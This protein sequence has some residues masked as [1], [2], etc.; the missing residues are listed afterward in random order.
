MEH[1]HRRLDVLQ[2]EEGGGEEDGEEEGEEERE[3]E[4]EGGG[5]EGKEGE[6]TYE[7]VPKGGKGATTQVLAPTEM[8]QEM[9]EEDEEGG[10][11]G[12]K[13]QGAGAEDEEEG[14]EEE[15]RG[16]NEQGREEEEEV[17]MDVD[18]NE[19]GPARGSAEEER[20]L[21]AT[22]T[23]S[24]SSSSTPKAHKAKGGGGGQTGEND[25][26]ESLPAPL[27][28]PPV[29]E[30]GE[31]EE[32]GA[33]EGKEGD[34]AE[35]GK[36]GEEEDEMGTDAVGA[37]ITTNQAALH[38][39]DALTEEEQQQQQQQ[40]HPSTKINAE[41]EREEEEEEAVLD[42]RQAVQGLWHEHPHPSPD[43]TM[44]LWSRYRSASAPLAL[45]LC[46][47][48]RL[49]LEPL[50]AS[51]LAGD[52]R[53][54]KRINMRRVIPY[55]ASGYR[56]DKIWLRR[57]KPAKRAYQVLLAIDDSGSMKHFEAEDM[58]LT[59]LATLASGMSTLEIGELGVAAFGENLKLVHGFGEPWTEEAGARVLSSF[60]FEQEAT[61]G[62]A[63]L[64]S[65]SAALEAAAG[66]AR[67]R[68]SSGMGVPEK[69]LQLVFVVSDGSFE[70]GDKATLRR[71]VREMA[72]KGQLLV[73][74]IVD[75]SIEERQEVE[76]SAAGGVKL[77]RYLDSY[78]FPYYV[79]LRDVQALPE[80]MA[81]ALKQWFEL[82]SRG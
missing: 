2:R 71:L 39:Q 72:E 80:V 28:P 12:E 32:K 37:K 49:V 33:E 1:W 19:D 11:E 41:D 10:E 13:K 59:A 29:P 34:D 63:M 48:L 17:G 22:A 20:K 75:K 79:V 26:G 56:K 40:S 73:L 55:I 16:E 18:D 69:I 3:G 23:S 68:R 76:Y 45:R 61:D 25:R 58:A 21:A 52:Y 7:H 82:L 64:G 67:Q 35:G 62:A 24:S 44:E 65:V 31:E 57:T 46:E 78:P 54:G 60:T 38:L 15:D 8:E 50:V 53:S 51:K 14:G 77:S 5:E 66:G 47:Q 4:E 81:D 27:P 6:G 74:L 42:L 9:E 36:N 43:T 70:R 30:E